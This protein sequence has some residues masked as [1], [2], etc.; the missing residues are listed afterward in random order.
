VSN[1]YIAHLRAPGRTV[2]AP[3]P[4]TGL[5]SSGGGVAS[6]GAFADVLVLALIFEK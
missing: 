1:T 3:E 4:G 5:M 6:G 2:A